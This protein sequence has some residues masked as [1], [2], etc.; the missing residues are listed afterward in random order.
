MPDDATTT[1]DPAVLAGWNP[2]DGEAPETG[3]TPP[4]APLAESDNIEDLKQ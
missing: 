2:E 4:V 3:H 1:P